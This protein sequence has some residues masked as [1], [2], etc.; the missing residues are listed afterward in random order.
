MAARPI[1]KHNNTAVYR[2]LIKHPSTTEP[3]F[4]SRP[5]ATVYIPRADINRAAY[6]YRQQIDNGPM[7]DTGSTTHIYDQ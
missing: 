2:P 1:I 3:I 6:L 7:V 4:S 5:A